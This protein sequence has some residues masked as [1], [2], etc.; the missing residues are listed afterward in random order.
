MKHFSKPSDYM[1]MTKRQLAYKLAEALSY[2]RQN[3]YR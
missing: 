1:K 2:I 3:M